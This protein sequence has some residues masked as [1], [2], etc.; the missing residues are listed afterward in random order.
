MRPI[1]FTSD[2]TLYFYGASMLI[3]A[4]RGFD[5]CEAL[6]VSSWLLNRRDHVGCGV[7]APVDYL[8]RSGR[9]ADAGS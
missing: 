1:A 6:A 5:G 8:E 9:R 7:F 2:A 4:W 3:A